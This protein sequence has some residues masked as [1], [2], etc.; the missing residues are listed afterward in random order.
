MFALGDGTFLSVPAYYI[1]G[2]D[3]FRCPTRI[4]A[5]A[6]LAL[7][8]LTAYGISNLSQKQVGG[9][10]IGGAILITATLAFMSL[11]LSSATLS[12]IGGPEGSVPFIVKNLIQEPHNLLNIALFSVASFLLLLAAKYRNRKLVLYA[13]PTLIGIELL[14]FFL[15]CS[16]DLR[17]QV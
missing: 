3:H 15:F 13:I 2:L 6:N 16:L 8:V 4:F 10:L 1:S 12:Q 5:I 14:S 11:Q 7:A 9:K 17:Q